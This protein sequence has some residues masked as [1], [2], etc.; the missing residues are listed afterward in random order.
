[1]GLNDLTLVISL[2]GAAAAAIGAGIW[3]LR[4]RCV[5]TVPPNRA[6]VLYGRRSVRTPSEPGLPTGEVEVHRP[7]VVVGGTVF[8]S[9]WNRGVGRV[10]L[11][12][13]SVDASVR[14]LYAVEGSRASGWEVRLQVQVKVPAEPGALLRAAESLLGKTDDE[15]RALVQ[16]TVEAAV[17]SVLSR[18]RREEGEPDWDRL[19]AEIQASVAPDLVAWGFVVRSLAVTD[20][21]RIVPLDIPTG[22]PP[23]KLRT[24]SPPVGEGVGI[25]PLRGDP[26]ARLGRAERN[27]AVVNAAMAR[28]YQEMRSLE[29]RL[30]GVSIFDLPLG[31]EA[32]PPL[33]AAEGFLGSPDES[34]EGDRSPS[35]SARSPMRE[36]ERGR[37]DG[38]APAD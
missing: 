31:V 11:D 30:A 18:L 28:C 9:P 7:R 2:S 32:S 29:G 22:H 23:M 3:A 24:F 13:V 5:L 17:P 6:L 35:S 15:I 33:V 20:L 12:P 26:E 19:A 1:M 14:S 21:R 4:T 10:S 25:D 8:V 38:P 27:L 36:L 37:A 34:P 16:R